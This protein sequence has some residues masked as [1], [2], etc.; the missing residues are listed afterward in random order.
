MAKVV[1]VLSIDGGGIR[2]IIP[3]MVLAEIERSTG[4]RIAELFDVI[5]GTSTGGILALALIKP[6]AQGK[7]EY[8]AED[9]I[10]LYKGEGKKIFKTEIFNRVKML[11]DEKYPNSNIEDVLQKYFGETP[12][13]RALTNVV[14]TSYDLKVRDT[15]LFKSSK[16]KEAPR[17]RD[18]KMK[19]VARAT[20][21]APTY[22]EPHPVKLPDNSRTLVLVD[23]GVFANNPAMCAYVEA[24]TLYKDATD[25]LVVSIGTGQLTNELK[26]D[27][28]KDW[29]LVEWA[30][31]ILNVVLDGVSDVVD[32]HMN[33]LLQGKDGTSS[34]YRFQIDLDKDRG[35]R[36]DDASDENINYLQNKVNRDILG[37]VEY[38]NKLKKL[39]ELL[40]RL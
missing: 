32:Y 7:P 18:F 5:A 14:I 30:Q 27:E 4:K 1:K 12:L 13:S 21:A 31:P 39:C 10:K 23:G 9:L 17:K 26:Y 25:F 2:G 3:A 29:G 8:T 22:F 33:E 34:Y 19:D 36:M 20:S 37:K 24:K 11:V 15:Y 6:N 38:Q 40:Q 35:D 16:A 28:V